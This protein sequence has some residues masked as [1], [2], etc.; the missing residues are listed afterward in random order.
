MDGFPFLRLW[1]ERERFYGVGWSLWSG[2]FA[3]GIDA[4]A[5]VRGAKYLRRRMSDFWGDIARKVAILR[6]GYLRDP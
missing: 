3:G 6:R 1:W 5:R 4:R 2:G